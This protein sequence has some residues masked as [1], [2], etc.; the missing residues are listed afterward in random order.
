PDDKTH[1]WFTAFA[2]AD[3]PEIVV[4]VLLEGAGEGSNEAAPVAKEL[5]AEWFRR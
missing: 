1:A 5:L 3:E 4:T 2:P